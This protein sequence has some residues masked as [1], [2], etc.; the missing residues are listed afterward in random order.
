[1]Q[2]EHKRFILVRAEECPTS[3]RG[4]ESC[5]IIHRNICSRGYKWVREGGDPRSQDV[6][7]VCGFSLLLSFLSSWKGPCL[8][9]LKMQGEHRVTCM[10]CVLFFLGRKSQSLQPCPIVGGVSLLEEWPLSSDAIA[11]CSDICSSV[12]NAATTCRIVITVA[13]CT[14]YTTDRLA[15]LLTSV[16]YHIYK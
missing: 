2:E 1:V 3:S 9:L 6:S 14:N 7:S 4:G 13:T 8:P 12:D 11:M 5:I 16:P 15:F 10:C